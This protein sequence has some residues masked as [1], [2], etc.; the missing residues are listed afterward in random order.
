[1]IYDIYYIYY[2]GGGGVN[3][4]ILVFVLVVIHMISI[5]VNSRIYSD[6]EKS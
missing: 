5:G 2:T 4:M 3:D 1:M 6:R